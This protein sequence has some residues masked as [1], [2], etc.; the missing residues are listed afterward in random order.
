[1]TSVSVPNFVHLMP[2][3]DFLRRMFESEPSLPAAGVFSAYVVDYVPLFMPNLAQY[4]LE[5]SQ[6]TWFVAFYGEPAKKHVAGF[7]DE[8]GFRQQIYSLDPNYF[9]IGMVKLPDRAS[10]NVPNLV[11]RASRELRNIDC[12]FGYN[13]R[14]QPAHAFH[15][16]EN[17]DLTA[18]L[19]QDDAVVD[20]PALLGNFA[21]DSGQLVGKANDELFHLHAYKRFDPAVSV[22]DIARYGNALCINPVTYDI[23]A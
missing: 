13:F 15:V 2:A 5:R 6:P 21:F 22:S 10:A 12:C 17:G 1:M 4:A 18:H 8:D 3:E 23:E 9:D 20:G 19:C 7:I 11:A 16:N 14:G